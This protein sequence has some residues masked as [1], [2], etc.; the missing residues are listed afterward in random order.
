M[1]N[2]T[3]TNSVVKSMQKEEKI[4]KFNIIICRTTEQTCEIQVTAKD[5][6]AAQAKAETLMNTMGFASKQDWELDS[7]DF[8]V[9]EVN[10]E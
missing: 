4:P 8:E 1:Q 9:Y 2:L 6:E 3:P 10:E 5:E 7:E